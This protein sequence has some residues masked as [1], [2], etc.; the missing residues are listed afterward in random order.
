MS[1]HRDSFAER[2]ARIES[3]QGITMAT[4]FVGMDETYTHGVPKH[5]MALKAV[6]L[7]TNAVL[8][9]SLLGAFCLGMFA[10]ALGRLV[11]FH[12]AAGADIVLEPDVEMIVNG[13]MG[14]AISFAVMQVF[15]LSSKEHVALQGAG[16]FAMVCT[17]HNLIHWLPGPSALLFSPEWVAAMVATSE[18]NSFFFRGAYFL[19]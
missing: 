12:M 9:L 11:R 1:L 13:L 7:Q 14:L 3:R 10:V 16:V 6:G 2:L 8:P 4:I 17:F 18:P 15:R 19:M 5:R